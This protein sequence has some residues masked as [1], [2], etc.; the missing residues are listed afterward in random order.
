MGVYAPTRGARNSARVRRKCL[1]LALA[2]GL[3]IGGTTAGA[4]ETWQVLESSV[5]SAAS[6]RLSFAL[7]TSFLGDRFETPVIAINGAQAG[8]TLCLTAAVHGNEINGSEVIRRLVTE[9]DAATLTG[10]VL[11]V[12]VVNVPGFQRAARDL[13]SGQDPNRYYPGH[14]ERDPAS[15]LAHRVLD[16]I[17]K[18]YCSHLVDLH[19]AASRRFNLPH[20]RVNPDAPRD[21]E[22]ASLFAPLPV[23]W[24]D[25]S[26][27][28]LRR[29]AG[30][31]GKPAVS[32]E[33]GRAETI[34]SAPVETVLDAI[35]VMMRQ[36]GMLPG[37]TSNRPS[38]ETFPD[39]RWLRAASGGLFITTRAAG[40]E[41]REGEVIG[42]IAN[43]VDGREEPVKAPSAGRLLGVADSQFVLPG[44]GIYHLGLRYGRD[45]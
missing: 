19:T 43:L 41:V 1:S 11:A 6:Q 28:M 8:P 35:I 20:L 39:S 45:R 7:G 42:L 24:E 31:L 32:V 2:T 29:A 27:R 15:R 4:G 12:P 14:P 23:L 21:V 13:P 36:L 26:A 22:F 16:G 25:G 33:F 5:P 18:P 37:A 10:R 34:Q 40:D 38:Q 30:R 44:Y 3:I 17:V 9:V